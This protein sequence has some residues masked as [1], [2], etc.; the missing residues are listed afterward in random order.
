MCLNIYIGSQKRIPQ[1]RWNEDSPGFY[2]DEVHE[3]NILEMVYP[4]LKLKYVYKAGSHMG[5]SCGFAYGKWS[6]ESEDED[7]SQRIQDVKDITEYFRKQSVNNELLVF[8]T[9][10]DEFSYEYKV[11]DFDPDKIDSEEFDFEE[12]VILKIV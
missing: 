3:K 7:H 9:W 10:W 5:C 4:I 6:K 8:C 2:L 1:V 12:N 11:L